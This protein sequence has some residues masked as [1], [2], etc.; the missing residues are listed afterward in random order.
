MHAGGGL[1]LTALCITTG[2]IC[3]LIFVDALVL[4][5]DGNVADALSIATRVS[6]HAR[7]LL[8][9]RQPIDNMQVTPVHCFVLEGRTYNLFAMTLYS[10]FFPPVMTCYAQPLPVFHI[11][12]SWYH[13]DHWG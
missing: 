10:P 4:N 2:K 13:H 3:W 6:P 9:T 12:S 11:C 1:D 7:C 8:C 5:M